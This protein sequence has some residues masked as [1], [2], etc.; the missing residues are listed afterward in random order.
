MRV[1]LVLLAG[2]LLPHS[3]VRAQ[4]AITEMM[5]SALTTNIDQTLSTNHSDFWELTNFGSNTVDLT[6]YRFTDSTHSPFALV[7]AGAPP[8]FIQ[9][10]ESIV[11]VRSNITHTEAQ[12]RTW[13]GSCVGPN[14][15]IRFFKN[16]G[17]SHN[18]DGI[19]V[20]DSMTNLVDS[21]DFGPATFGVS[22]VY[23]TVTGEFGALSVLG[24]G[25]ACRAATAADVGS[26]GVNTGPIPLRIVQQP[27]NLAVCLG[28]DA[29]F[30][31]LAVG[32]PRPRYQW[33]F[34][35]AAIPGENDASLTIF[36]ATLANAG[37]YRVVITNGLSIAQS[38]SVLLSVSTNLAAVSFFTLPVNV[39]VVTNRT[40]RFSVS[41]CAYPAARLQWFSNGVAVADATNQMLLIRNCALESS[42]AEI[43]VRAANSLGTN[44]ACAHL[45]VTTKPDLRFTE[46]QAYPYTACNAHHDWFEVTN[47]GTNAVDLLGYH[48]SDQPTLAG[49]SVVTQPM[50]VQPGESVVF[51]KNPVASIFVDW[52]GADQLPP[53]LKIFPYGGFSLGR[54][55]DAL[56]LWDASAELFDE[57]IDSIS[58]A[59]VT[60]G[61][62]LQF[63]YDLFPFGAYSVPG[64]YG[65]FRATECGDI[66]SPGYTT[67]PPPRFVSISKEVDGAHL[68][69]RAVE[70]RTYQLGYTEDPQSSDWKPLGI[71]TATN[72]VPVITDPGANNG[73]NRFYHLLQL[74]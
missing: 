14:V 67:N 35:D 59:G 28:L 25:G 6:R 22:F 70:G 63:D 1:A 55:G 46:V 45:Y 3:T 48:F 16:P 36:G 13:W 15:Q 37:S 18:G 10:S 51:A 17:F 69:W 62:S 19:R 40:A 20:Y 53:G 68:K 38:A 33:F 2:A 8:L 9:P 61:A 57:L 58:F 50:V 49:A 72:S 23:D 52:W 74:P 4:L 42:G 54:T 27:T 71:T 26:P 44:T 32:M 29:T 66:G 31:V 34:N 41:V 7:P 65:A 43:C 60:N 56:Y 47:F 24:Q 39:T 30:N 73:S 21:V 5:S 64:E 11:F 12:F